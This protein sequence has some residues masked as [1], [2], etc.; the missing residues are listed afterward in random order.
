M[1]AIAREVENSLRGGSHGFEMRTEELSI[2][3]S[4]W[5]LL[6]DSVRPF[7]ERTARSMPALTAVLG[8]MPVMGVKTGR[9]GESAE[10]EE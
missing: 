1:K 7:F 6:P 2:F 8:R 5:S 3:G 9:K 4:E 10:A